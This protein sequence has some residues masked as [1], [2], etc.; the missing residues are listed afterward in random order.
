MSE[1]IILNPSKKQLGKL[2][3]VIYYI[4]NKAT[5]QYYIGKT[6]NTLVRRYPGGWHRSTESPYLIN[7]LKK[8]GLETF[9]FGIIK[10]SINS[11]K[12]LLR[13]ESDFALKYNAYVP[14]G[15]NIA[16]C[17]QNT[18]ITDEF[19]LRMASTNSKPFEVK[20]SMTGEIIRGVNFKKFCKDNNIP[21]TIEILKEV[22]IRAGKYTNVNTEQYDLNNRR[23]Y[24]IYNIRPPYKL[25]D[26]LGNEIIFY[27]IKKFCKDN[28][29]LSRKIMHLLLG[30]INHFKNFF[31][32]K[33]GFQLLL[34]SRSCL[35]DAESI[36]LMKKSKTK[37]KGVSEV[38]ILR[39]KSYNYHA[40]ITYLNVTY[41]KHF[42]N[43]KDALVYRDKIVYFIHR[44]ISMLNDPLVS[45]NFNEEEAS[46]LLKNIA[47]KREKP[48]MSTI[49]YDKSKPTWVFGYPFRGK[50][51][52]KNFNTEFECKEFSDRCLLFLGDTKRKIFYPENKEKYSNMNNDDILEYLNKRGMRSL[53]PAFNQGTRS[54]EE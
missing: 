28:R 53:I 42:I 26:K 4:K 2:K 44:D 12:E 15:F 47:K 7:S 45:V 18:V 36:N 23:F 38:Y 20:D 21:Y 37:Y 24:K 30:K 29:V 9:E 52:R 33:N 49:G 39:S 46:V 54:T 22:G 25:Y 41:V 17:G 19:R 50:I 31:S 11:N 35:H 43:L 6:S 51:K 5:N 10:H 16:P 48:I 8:Y 3:G 27:D 1:E 14:S 13:L 40:R 32:E 34:K